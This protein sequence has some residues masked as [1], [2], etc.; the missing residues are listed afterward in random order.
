MT[1][2]ASSTNQSTAEAAHAE[3]ITFADLDLSSGHLRV[4]TR[5]GTISW[6]GNSYDGV[7]KFGTI[8]EISED[9]MLRPNGVTVAISGVD[10]A[11]ITAAMDET[12]HGRTITLYQGFLNTSTFA[13]VDSPEVIFRGLMDVMTVELGPNTGTIQIAC[14][15][16]LA[17]WQRFT[18]LLYTH[19]SQQTLYAG[20][21][22][23]DLVPA[24]QG[25]TI[26]WIKK[27]RFPDIWTAASAF[28][29]YKKGLS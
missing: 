6:G 8:S 28:R 22:G 16:E 27:S 12:Y 20:D 29:K 2:Y 23:F 15:G 14:E 24:I 18:N 9:S 25:R 21:R 13:L 26:N 19:E 11:L 17:R 10:A 3:L 5:T 4:H 7:G 1:A